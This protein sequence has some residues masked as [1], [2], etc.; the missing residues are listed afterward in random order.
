MGLC[1][2]VFMYLSTYICIYI[3]IL[4]RICMYTYIFMYILCIIYVCLHVYSAFII[5]TH[6][7]L[8]S[9]PNPQHTPNPI[10]TLCPHYL[11]QF[12][13]PQSP[14]PLYIT[15]T[16]IWIDGDQTVYLVRV[17]NLVCQFREDHWLDL[18]ENTVQ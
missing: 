16:Y 9:S 14:V 10:N 8:P 2:Y 1:K 4:A 13:T 17:W 3:C 15:C 5:S 11:V 6:R 18:F 12:T 7:K